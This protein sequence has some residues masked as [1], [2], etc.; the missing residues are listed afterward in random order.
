MSRKLRTAI[1]ASIMLATAHAA[2]AADAFSELLNLKLA[3]NLTVQDEG[4]TLRTRGLEFAGYLVTNNPVPAG[5]QCL[6]AEYR[7]L[8]TGPRGTMGTD[9][10]SIDNKLTFSKYERIVSTTEW[11][12]LRIYFKPDSE[13][14][15]RARIVP[16][17]RLSAKTSLELRNLKIAPYVRPENL[18]PN[19]DF[20]SGSPGGLPTTWFL[21]HPATPAEDVALVKEEGADRL[22]LKIQSDGSPIGAEARTERL[23]ASIGVPW[24][25]AGT[26][27]LS[28]RAKALTDAAQLGLRVYAGDWSFNESKSFALTREWQTFTLEL[29]CPTEPASPWIHARLETNE[30]GAML[31]TDARMTWSPAA[32]ATASH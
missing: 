4:Q 14:K 18:L 2:H 27:K 13:Q 26:V 15:V 25:G 29:P 19:G 24:P 22:V 30:P 10:K 11:G 6:E 21:P 23:L 20:Q 16:D 9:V 28:V 1:A 12:K 17:A 31:I 7:T 32:P 3:G 5:F 8:G